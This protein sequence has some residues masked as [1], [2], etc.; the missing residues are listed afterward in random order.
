MFVGL[1]GAQNSYAQ[2]QTIRK[3]T[4]AQDVF[5]FRFDKSVLEREYMGNAVTMARLDSMLSDMSFVANM[6]SIVINA[7]S[8]PEGVVEYNRALSKRRGN[9]VRRYILNK[10]PSI[11]EDMVIM[12]SVDE[13]WKGLRELVEKDK[14]APYRERIL[15][16][17]DSDVN[18]GT[19]EWRLK[20]LAGGA[21]WK[22][23]TNRYLRYLRIGA[24]SVI[25]YKK[26]EIPNEPEPVYEVIVTEEIIEKM[27]PEVEEYIRKPLFALKTNLLLDAATALNVELEVPVGNRFSVSGEW[28]FPWWH[29]NDADW[30]MQML[31]AHG[32]FKY[33]LGDRSKREVLTGW[34]LGVNGGWAKYDFQLFDRKGEQGHLFDVGVQAGYAHKIARN[35]RMEYTLGVGYMRN[36]YKKYDEVKDTQFG[37]IKVFRFPWET[38]RRSWIG[39]TSAKIS[40][41]WLLDYKTKRKEGGGK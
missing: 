12:H 19:K 37:D 14:N 13:N 18:P 20:N 24:T 28:M 39:P 23:I 21:P 33:W 7:T 1:T 8:S 25:F 2:L 5:Y 35:L 40:F 22:Y 16:I 3:D 41:V 29:K 10:Y 15:Q 6:D 38:R 30:T 26:T 31:S 4:I 27:E 11:T 36:D 32:A 17:I 9:T 34:H